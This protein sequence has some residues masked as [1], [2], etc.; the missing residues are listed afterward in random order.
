[1][2]SNKFFRT[3]SQQPLSPLLPRSWLALLCIVCFLP[4]CAL[5][6]GSIAK[7]ED[8]ALINAQLLEQQQEIIAQHEKLDNIHN[9]QIHHHT[10]T[11]SAQAETLRSLTVLLNRSNEP[12]SCPTI[13]ILNDCPQQS[14]PASEGRNSTDKQIIGE[15]EFIRLMPPDGAYK[16]RIDTGATT[17]SLDARDIEKFERDGENWVR[18][19]VPA[20]EGKDGEIEMEEPVARFARIIQSSAEGDERRPVIKLQFELG[21]TK[22]M[23]EFTLSDRSHLNYPVLVGRNI[24]RD[25][26]VVDVSKKHMTRISRDTLAAIEEREE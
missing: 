16:A 15:L 2:T 21:E 19:T 25:L 17:S 26:L 10:T 14:D 8:V 24:L 3:R 5:L 23:A 22:R 6:D 18:F 9:A 11:I 1:M 7:N 20:P 13:D 12:R 4:A